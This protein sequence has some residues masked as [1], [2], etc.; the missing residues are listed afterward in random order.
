M[1]PYEEQVG[2]G[3]A[4]VHLVQAPQVSAGIRS[5]LHRGI[6]LGLD[7]RA[8]YRISAGSWFVQPQVE[9]VQATLSD[10]G[11]TFRHRETTLGFG[12]GLQSW[13]G[14]VHLAAGPEAGLVLFDDVLQPTPPIGA[15][16]PPGAQKPPESAPQ[17]IV[18]I[19]FRAGVFAQAALRTVDR[20]FLTLDVA[21]GVV[22]YR[23][24]GRRASSAVV[25][26][27]LGLLYSFP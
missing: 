19:G 27:G 7:L 22:L 26:G 14:P 1:L 9:L 8:A 17:G 11:R 13:A 15:A 10:A 12:G 3:D 25:G 6:G 18:P 4:G 16:A 23:N 5:A 2:K 24:E 21:P 20:L